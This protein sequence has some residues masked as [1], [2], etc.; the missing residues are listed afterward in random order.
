[1]TKCEYATPG[2]KINDD[3]IT[4]ALCKYDIYK[5]CP[6][7]VQRTMH[8]NFPAASGTGKHPLCFSTGVKPDLEQVA[9]KEAGHA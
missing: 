9:A 4:P 8:V 1:M 3:G 2:K 6:Y 5:P 7:G